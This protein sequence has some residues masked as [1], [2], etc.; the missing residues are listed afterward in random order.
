[1]SADF[2]P[3]PHYS[4]TRI[5]ML[6]SIIWTLLRTSARWTI[7][8]PPDARTSHLRTLSKILETGLSALFRA[9]H[10]S[11]RASRTLY[12]S[13]RERQHLSAKLFAASR[14]VVRFVFPKLPSHRA[15]H[16]TACFRLVNCSSKPPFSAPRQPYKPVSGP[17]I[18]Q[19][20][21]RPS[22]PVETALSARPRRAMHLLSGAAHYAYMNR[23]WEALSRKNEQGIS[24][25]RS[26]ALCDGLNGRFATWS[27][28]QPQA[29]SRQRE[30][31]ITPP[32]GRRRGAEA[33]S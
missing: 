31:G 30:R 10:R 16:L 27:G 14:L 2:A 25:P 32:A 7:I 18:L 8:H 33:R 4:I 17:R 28:P 26:K 15:A 22:T 23:A 6:S 19:Q 24:W 12:S 3:G 1:L 21:F 11:A 9:R 5:C 20:C 29:L 13:F